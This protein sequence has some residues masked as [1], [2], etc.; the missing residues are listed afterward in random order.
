MTERKTRNRNN[1]ERGKAFEKKMAD[2]LGWIRVAYSGVNDAFGWGD[3]RDQEDREKSLFLGECKSMTPRSAKEI[4]FIIKESWLVGDGSIVAKA[5]KTSKFPVLFFTKV[6]S[7]LTFVIMR[8][9]EFKTVTQMV[10]V[11]RDNNLIDD[12]ATSNVDELRRQIAEL[13]GDDD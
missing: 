1:R 3:I 9:Q 8:E 12:A 4:N 13:V 7:S 6:R 5:R 2:F 11:L 10:K